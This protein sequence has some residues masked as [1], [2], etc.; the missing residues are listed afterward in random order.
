MEE[1]KTIFNYIGQV[2]STFG[3]IV[4]IFIV[5]GLLIGESSGEYS[6]LFRL[7]REGLTIATLLQL[8]LLSF[9]IT[10]SQVVF[11]TDK[12]IK[13]MMILWRNILFFLVIMLAIVFMVVLFGW[14]PLSDFKAWI[15]FFLSYTVS[16][17]I[18][19]LVSGIKERAEDRRMQEALEKFNKK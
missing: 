10:I 15:G 2:F 11:Q 16:M 8:L 17:M 3:I 5:F 18:S 14:F 19:I 7:G 9:V 4:T 13:N 12:W 1:N 6:S